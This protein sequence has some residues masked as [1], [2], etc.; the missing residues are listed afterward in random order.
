MGFVG[1]NWLS[2]ERLPFEVFFS[3]LFDG[4]LGIA[5]ANMLATTQWPLER[6]ADLTSLVWVCVLWLPESLMDLS[7]LCSTGHEPSTPS[8]RCVASPVESEARKL[9]EMS[10]GRLSP[11]S[12][13]ESAL[14]SSSD[15]GSSS[16][17]VVAASLPS[18]GPTDSSSTVGGISWF[19]QASGVSVG[20]SRCPIPGCAFVGSIEQMGCH[21]LNVYLPW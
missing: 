18:Q 9:G 19:P 12:P 1:P 11:V 20:Q 17:T 4:P 15:E 7:A 21:A 6:A 16:S 13:C 2:C 14:L 5:Y 3:C 8:K 10:P